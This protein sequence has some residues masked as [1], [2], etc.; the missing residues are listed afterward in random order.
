[1]TDESKYDW[2]LQGLKSDFDLC[3]IFFFMHPWHNIDKEIKH[4]WT[5]I[6][7]GYI[8]CPDCLVKH[9]EKVNGK[10]ELYNEEEVIL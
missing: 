10:I 8:P 2:F 3:C 4:D 1:M 6:S 9:M 7:S 5:S